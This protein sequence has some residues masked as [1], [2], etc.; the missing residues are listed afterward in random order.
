MAARK[1]IDIA[2]EPHKQQSR[3]A[4][5]KQADN[6]LKQQAGRKGQNRETGLYV[7]RAEMQMQM[8]CD[9]GAEEEKDQDKALPFHPLLQT[10]SEA[11]QLSSAFLPFSSYSPSI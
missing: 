7:C 10:T 5:L 2:A 3:T 1:P 6:G 11:A 4:L 9:A 8:L